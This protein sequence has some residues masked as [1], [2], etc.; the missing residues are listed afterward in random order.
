MESGVPRRTAGRFWTVGLGL[1][2]SACTPTPAA[3]DP[4]SRPEAWVADTTENARP[5]AD[6]EILAADIAAHLQATVRITAAAPL[7]SFAEAYALGSPPDCP[8]PTVTASPDYGTTLYFDGLCT[9]GP[10]TY[11]GPAL[12][13]TW[14]NQAIQPIGPMI[15][16]SALPADI[17]WSGHAF[18]GQT[19]IY[20]EDGRLDFNCSCTMVN[21][22]GT[23]AAGAQW[24]LGNTEGVAHWTGP[25]GVGSWMDDPAVNPSLQI[26]ATV[27]SDQK[28]VSSAG[29]LSG[30][31]E[32][33]RAMG[34]DLHLTTDGERYEGELSL[35]YRD[36]RDAR[37]ATLDF[38]VDAEGQAC[39][40]DVCLDLRPMLEFRSFPWE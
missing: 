21:L 11:K 35:D 28:S 3:E 10:M 23:D 15:L 17:L 33:Y 24:F 19:D 26:G 27:E 5:D 30:V 12:Y 29:T 40:G 37:W 25:A 9:R 13:Y 1:L 7:A 36:D 32:R 31:G 39:G 2:P 16:A 6:P 34:W 4:R 8:S 20:S 22:T 14:E 38:E 18:N